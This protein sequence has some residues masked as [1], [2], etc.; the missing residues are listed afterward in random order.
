MA[1]DG[2]VTAAKKFA[3]ERMS[4]HEQQVKQQHGQTKV[5]V[6]LRTNN[7]GEVFSL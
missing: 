4:A 3:C 6:V 1:F 5:V 2:H 7:G